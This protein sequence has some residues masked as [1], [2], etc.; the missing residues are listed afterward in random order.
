MKEIKELA[1]KK[2]F[3]RLF[4]ESGMTRHKFERELGILLHQLELENIEIIN[5]E[6]KKAKYRLEKD[7]QKGRRSP[8]A[9]SYI[10]Y[11]KLLAIKI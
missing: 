11:K 10:E 8:I 5:Q 6:L 7:L 3:Q 1:S 2:D 9:D 4:Q